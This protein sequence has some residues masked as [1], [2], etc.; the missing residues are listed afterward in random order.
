MKFYEVK[1]FT[2]EKSFFHSVARA[3]S[4]SEAI[5]KA[6]ARLVKNWPGDFDVE[7]TTK[8]EAHEVDSKIYYEHL[9]TCRAEKIGVYD[10]EVKGNKMIYL[11]YF[12]YEGFY[13]VT[14]NLDTDTET[15]RHQAST[16]KSYNY[17]C[18]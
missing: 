6:G 4:D 16:K 15:R 13:K 5:V 1:F 18:G 9:A 2:S 14:H 7:K 12:G 17:Y 8:I 11:S 10:Y 3:E